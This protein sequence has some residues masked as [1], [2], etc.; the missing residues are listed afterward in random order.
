M[1]AALLA[2]GDKLLEESN[3]AGVLLRM[4]S[5]I[6]RQQK[7]L[8]AVSTQTSSLALEVAELR[9]QSKAAAGFQ[10]QLEAMSSEMKELKG[11]TCSAQERKN[12]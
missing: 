3:L 8:E 9:E 10:E 1:S 6:E 11:S 12:Y 2:Y 5:A 4:G 7:D